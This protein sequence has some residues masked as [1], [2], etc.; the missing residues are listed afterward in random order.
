MLI[1]FNISS[2]RIFHLHPLL[3][4]FHYPKYFKKA[5]SSWDQFKILVAAYSYPRIVKVISFRD[6]EYYNIFP[7]DL[8]GEI[9][10]EN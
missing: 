5:G 2:S 4:I 3:M 10:G 1:L 9:P 8:L 7:M 6:A